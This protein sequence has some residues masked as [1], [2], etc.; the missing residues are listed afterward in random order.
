MKR[1]VVVGAGLGGLVLAHRLR[2]D[3]A[4]RVEVVLLERAGRAGGAVRSEWLD[5]VLCEHGPL[6]IPGDAPGLR[7]LVDETGLARAFRPAAEA[8]QRRWVLGRGRLHGFPAG[9]GALFASGMLSVRGLL[10]LD[11]AAGAP[12]GDET[13]RDHAARRAG[14]QFADTLVDGLAAEAFGG[15]AAALDAATCVPALRERTGRLLDAVLPDGRQTLHAGLHSFDLG[16]QVLPDALA[17]ALGP[18][19]RLRTGARAVRK[20]AAGWTVALQGGDAL[21]ADHVVLA[22]PPAE[23][24][25]L[26][27]PALRDDAARFLRGIPHATVDVLHL[28]LPEA[29]VPGVLRLGT[30]APVLVP[31]AEARAA[32]TTVLGV[33]PTRALFPHHGP[34]DTVVLRALAGGARG[35]AEEPLDEAL[36][37]ATDEVTLLLGLRKAPRL[38]HGTRCRQALPQRA[39]GH[40]H[41]AEALQGALVACPGVSVMGVGPPGLGEAL[42]EAGALARTLMT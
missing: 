19:L 9:R 10:G 38:L 16:M 23:A 39:P 12:A 13:L 22:T 31:G 25:A 33:T 14:R 18:V 34:R 24:A 32:G 26:L 36:R 35:G 6:T 11:R 15:E 8:A 2:R 40:A 28:V 17:A 20:Q 30:A 29:D 37:R 42:R 21:V 3:A 27:G 7:A 5:G 1:V 41:S 4:G